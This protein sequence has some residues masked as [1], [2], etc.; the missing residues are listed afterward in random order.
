MRSLC[1]KHPALCLPFGGQEFRKGWNRFTEEISQKL[2]LLIL[3]SLFQGDDDLGCQVMPAVGWNL[4]VAAL[5]RNTCALTGSCPRCWAS[6]G[7]HRKE[8]EDD[9]LRE[10]AK[11]SGCSQIKAEVAKYIS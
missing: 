6:Q 3:Q 7:H 10:V 5:W 9:D 11:K 1:S 2:G 8:E 4:S